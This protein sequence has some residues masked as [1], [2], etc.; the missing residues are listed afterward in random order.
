MQMIDNGQIKDRRKEN[1]KDNFDFCD[2]NG[3]QLVGGFL[4]LL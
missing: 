1:E 3:W 2:L 4:D